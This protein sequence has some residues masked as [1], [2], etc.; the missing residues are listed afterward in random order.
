MSIQIINTR[1]EAKSHGIKVLVYGK[2]G[3]GKTYLARTA[4][5]PIILSAESGILSLGDIDLPMVKV[6]T[7]KDL[8]NF[9]QWVTTDPSARQFKTIYVDSLTEIGEV[10]LANSK[11]VVKDQRQAYTKLMEDMIPLIKAY[12]DIPNMHVV[13]TAKL[14]GNKDEHTGII[15]QGPM[16]PGNKMGQQ[17]PY[18]FDEVFRLGI[19]KTPANAEYRY[20]QTAPDLQY[21]G[22]DRSG[23]LDPIE[24]P[25]LSF[26]FNK[27]LQKSYN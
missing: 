21:E 6:K 19:G 16:M 22:K 4:P 12:R 9:Y 14:E 2:A 11:A 18:L 26:I 8:E 5:A 15:M 27:I 13:M 24:P 1:D 20:L 7:I 23:A 17:L 10:V 25:D 3:V